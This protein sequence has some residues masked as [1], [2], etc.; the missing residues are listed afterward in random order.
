[1]RLKK[2]KKTIKDNWKLG[3]PN[4]LDQLKQKLSFSPVK[5]VKK[6]RQLKWKFSVTFA[7][8]L[9]CLVLGSLLL[10]E[11]AF[12]KNKNSDIIGNEDGGINDQDSKWKSDSELDEDL[13]YDTIIR[14]QIDGT[15]LTQLESENDEV[16][17]LLENLPVKSITPDSIAFENNDS[18]P[19]YERVCIYLEFPNRNFKIVNIKDKYF[20]ITSDNFEK[21]YFE[22]TDASTLEEFLTKKNKNL[23]SNNNTNQNP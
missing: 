10:R 15:D 18:A 12:P 19:K 7:S 22:V 20:L 21:E 16:I 5:T 14:Y 2:I 6:G 8:L 11:F 4:V 13:S 23:G 3:T 17:E 9:F 1:V